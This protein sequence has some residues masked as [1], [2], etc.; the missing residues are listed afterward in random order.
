MGA[1][2]ERFSWL[3]CRRINLLGD[4]AE[5]Q[6]NGGKK[7]NWKTIVLIQREHS[8]TPLIRTQAAFL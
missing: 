3:G 1:G 6:E 8:D 2:R 5:K 7:T 4:I